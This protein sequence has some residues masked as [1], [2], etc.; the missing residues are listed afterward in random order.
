VD[1]REEREFGV[2]GIYT[3]CFYLSL[4]YEMSGDGGVKGRRGGNR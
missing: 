2:F 1:K 4:G 3:L